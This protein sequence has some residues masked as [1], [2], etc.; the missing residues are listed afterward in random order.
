MLIKE[1]IHQKTK[2]FLN[3]CKPIPFPNCHFQH[4]NLAMDNSVQKERE[5]LGK[6]N[7]VIILLSKSKKE[8]GEYLRCKTSKAIDSKIIRVQKKRVQMEFLQKKCLF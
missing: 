1:P 5:I 7:R 6:L 4:N 8:T 2:I 3:I